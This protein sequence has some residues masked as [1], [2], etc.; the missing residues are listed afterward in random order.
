MREI[1][2]TQLVLLCAQAQASNTEELRQKRNQAE[3]ICAKVRETEV[4]KFIQIAVWMYEHL[5]VRN[6]VCTAVID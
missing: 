6:E 5:E 2:P 1:Q 3:E 4:W